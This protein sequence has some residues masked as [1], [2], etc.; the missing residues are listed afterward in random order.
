M[1]QCLQKGNPRGLNPQGRRQSKPLP[2]AGEPAQAHAEARP[3]TPAAV[4][5]P[6]IT[7]EQRATGGGRR[8]QSVEQQPAGEKTPEKVQARKEAVRKAAPPQERS[9]KECLEDQAA[10]RVHSRTRRK[11]NN[12][13]PPD[14]PRDPW[15]LLPHWQLPSAVASPPAALAAGRIPEKLV[16]SLSWTGI[17]VGTATQEIIRA[18]PFEKDRIHGTF[19]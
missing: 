6:D 1:N 7:A 14:S 19:Q 11:I 10:G 16:Y 18:W 5:Q 9:R 15:S 13:Q 17:P 8:G 4:K 12:A 3:S 2:L